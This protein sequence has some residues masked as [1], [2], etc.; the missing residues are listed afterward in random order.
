MEDGGWRK[1]AGGRTQRKTRIIGRTDMEMREDRSTI[2]DLMDDYYMAFDRVKEIKEKIPSHGET[3]ARDALPQ[4]EQRLD[5]AIAAVVE[6]V[7]KEEP[8]MT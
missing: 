7:A 6:Y 8:C 3:Y 4:A 2:W 5:E 1:D